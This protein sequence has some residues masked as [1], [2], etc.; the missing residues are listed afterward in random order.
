MPIIESKKVQISFI[1][2]RFERLLQFGKQD[3][4]IATNGSLKAAGICMKII[5]LVL[6]MHQ[7]PEIQRHLQE[8]GG[9]LLDLIL[10]AVKKYVSR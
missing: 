8:S 6:D 10:R 7:D 4:I 2:A 5:S 1:P 9:T 3:Y